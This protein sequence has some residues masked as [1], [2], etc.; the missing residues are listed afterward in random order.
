M[1][2][3]WNITAESARQLI[4]RPTW[5]A[6]R[7]VG[8]AECVAASRVVE[9][10]ERLLAAGGGLLVLPYDQGVSAATVLGLAYNVLDANHRVLVHNP[11]YEPYVRRD[12]LESVGWDVLLVHNLPE[13]VGE[14]VLYDIGTI[15]G[16]AVV[17]TAAR[18]Q[19]HDLPS[20]LP[21][22]VLPLDWGEL[23]RDEQLIADVVQTE[24][25]LLSTTPRFQTLYTAVASCDIFGIPF[26]IDLLGPVLAMDQLEAEALLLQAA[27]AGVCHWWEHATPH[28]YSAYTRDPLICREV[29]S[30]LHSGGAWERISNCHVS[31]GEAAFGELQR[32]DFRA[33][34]QKLFRAVAD[35]VTMGGNRYGG[36][37]D[38]QKLIRSTLFSD[39]ARRTRFNHLRRELTPPERIL[40]ADLF[41]RLHL[42]EEAEHALT[43]DEENV[44]LIHRWLRLRVRQ[45][46]ERLIKPD[47]AREEFDRESRF[48]NNPYFHQLRGVLETRLGAEGRID[49]ARATFRKAGDA[50]EQTGVDPVPTWIAW[51]DL[52]LSHPEGDSAEADKLL[53]KVA[54]ST[55]DSPHLFHLRARQSAERLQYDEADSY[56]R[57]LLEESPENVPAWNLLG[58]FSLDRG[59]FA[60]AAAYLDEGLNID[61]D[62]LPC[63]LLRGKVHAEQGAFDEAET[64]FK[65]MLSVNERSRQ[66][67][68]EL[69][70]LFRQRG[71]NN[72]AYFDEALHQL[73]Q[74]LEQDADNVYAEHQRA[75][76]EIAQANVDRGL[77]RL[78]SIVQSREQAPIPVLISLFRN[79]PR[80]DDTDRKQRV[81]T[82]EDWAEEIKWQIEDQHNRF[83]E[84]GRAGHELIQM[85]NAYAD[86]L[87]KRLAESIET[88]T[89]TEWLNDAGTQ[90]Q[91]S[92]ELDGDNA[93]TLRLYA[94][95]QGERDNTSETRARELES[96]PPKPEFLEL[97]ERVR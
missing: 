16:A 79:S 74:V 26:P 65:H 43:S 40:W 10:V 35:G 75:E 34:L 66:A 30:K 50:A 91:A 41:E 88:E 39:G 1:K 25:E 87:L 62:N 73:Q 70:G 71:R 52:E 29:L 96:A 19:Y 20:L 69:A 76:L 6:P 78:R 17:G 7:D 80:R 85:R 56:V 8:A 93:Y 9:E 46:E 33:V 51:A 23:Q 81:E 36:A 27:E 72:E 37:K 59:H 60:R 64:L 31:I 83:K 84:A 21:G 47:E 5:L 53:R 22:E 89:R 97:R 32:A 94:Q 68:V 13:S 95:F 2:P 14:S 57:R 12:L 18:A 54:D 63:L 28:G 90:I 61:P 38:V 44:Y 77:T 49:V 92:L 48:D 86:A 67:R 55:P 58:G 45:A 82:A 3:E 4:D 15:K 11:R 42:L 24:Y